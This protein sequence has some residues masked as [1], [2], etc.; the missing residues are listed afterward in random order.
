MVQQVQHVD[1]IA[2]LAEALDAPDPLLQAGRIPRQI[3]V[4]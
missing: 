3:D 1:A 4:D 2:A